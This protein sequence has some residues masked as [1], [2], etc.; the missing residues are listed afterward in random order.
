MLS[1]F[2]LCHSYSFKI[3]LSVCPCQVF[4]TCIM[5]QRKTGVHPKW[6]QLSGLAPGLACKYKSS[7][8]ENIVKDKHCSLFCGATTLSTIAISMMT[9]SITIK[10]ATLGIMSLSIT[11]LGTLYCNA[12]CHYA[13]HNLSRVSQISPL[14]RVSLIWMLLCSVLWILF[15]GLQYKDITIVRMKIT[16]IIVTPRGVIYALR[17]VN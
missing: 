8:K 13:E 1:N 12:E 6:S 4:E 10:N 16:I 5:F 14:Y 2:F 15:C 17:V 9:L 11:A 3:S 7:Q